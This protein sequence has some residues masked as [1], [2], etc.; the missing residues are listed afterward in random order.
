[1][2]IVFAGYQ[3]ALETKRMLESKVAS[4]GLVLRAFPQTAAG[5]TEDAVKATPEWRE[6]R[7]RFDTAFRQ[8]Q[9]FN[10][11]FMR[12][13]GKE[14]KSDLERCRKRSLQKKDTA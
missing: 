11:E 12:L 14:Y 2:V 13:Y 8:L 9:F 10:K 3:D 7:T 1:M 6:A 5:L 4:L